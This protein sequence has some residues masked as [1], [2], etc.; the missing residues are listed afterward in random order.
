[1]LTFLSRSHRPVHFESVVASK[2]FEGC[3]L[4]DT[5]IINHFTCK[6]DVLHFTLY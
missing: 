3:N 4:L 6:Q 5:S 1:M 2:Y